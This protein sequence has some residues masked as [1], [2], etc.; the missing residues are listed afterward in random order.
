MPVGVEVKDMPPPIARQQA[1]GADRPLAKTDYERVADGY[2]VIEPLV[3]H[4][5]Q[6]IDVNK[7]V[8]G[9]FKGD[10][11]GGFTQLLANGNRLVSSNVHSDV[12]GKGGGESWMYRRIRK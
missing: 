12:F 11:Q 3:V 8:V 10:Y 6:L 4:E 5:S 9:S 1:I 7:N 2:V